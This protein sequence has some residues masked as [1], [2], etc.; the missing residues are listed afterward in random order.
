MRPS[1]AAVNLFWQKKL[2][3]IYKAISPEEM[4]R[5]LDYCRQHTLKNKG[6]FEVYPGEED[7][8]VTVIVNA[9]QENEPLEKF[10]PLGAFYCN[11]LGLGIISMDQEEAGYDA[12]P[13]AKKHA[14][15]IQQVVDIL[16]EKAYP[17][18][19]LKFPV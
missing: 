15:A 2:H 19:E 3:I 10:K 13:T 6:P 7:S 11:Y 17:G 5:V 16:V 9:L 14:R 12:M 18:A 4:N 8:Q 1:P